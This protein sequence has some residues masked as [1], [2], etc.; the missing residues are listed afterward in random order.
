MTDRKT[1]TGETPEVVDAA[2][3]APVPPTAEGMAA[4]D[5]P[6]EHETLEAAVAGAAAAVQDAV[7][8][9]AERKL[10]IGAKLPQGIVL[11]SR[12]L[13]AGGKKGGGGRTAMQQR[14]PDGALLPHV[15]EAT[16]LS[17]ANKKYLV[18]GDGIMAPFMALSLRSHGI[19][20][21]LAHHQSASDLD[22]GTI[23]LT[24]SVT[25]LLGDVLNVSVPSGSVVGR[26]LIFDHVGNDM[27]DMD[28]NEFREKGESPT[29]F[30]C[31]RPKI[32][33]ALLSLC[34][35]GAQSCTVMPKATVEKGGVQ[36]CGTGVR[37]TFTTGVSHDY[38]GIICTAR[39]Q[40][41]VPELTLTNEELQRREENNQRYKAALPTANRWLEVCVPPLPELKKF[42]KRFTPGSQEIVEILT[43]REAKMT[44][45][46]TMMATKLFYNVSLVIPESAS[47]PL[48]RS[49]SMKQFWDEVVEH[50]TSGIPGYISHTLFKP[51]FTHVQ[52][53]FKKTHACCFRAPSFVLPY[54][55]E[56]DGRVMKIAHS[57][58]ACNHDAIDI[59]DAQ[60]FS[61]C[62]LL[63]RA[64]SE[65]K[66][67]PAFL[68]TR[69]LQVLEE[70][71][72]HE[73]ITNFS[74]RE[75]GQFAYMF[76][77]FQMKILRRYTRAWKQILKNHVSVLPKLK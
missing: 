50:W 26:I 13:A 43:P 34:K 41:L 44:V 37:V 24:P 7:A 4:A 76:S 57:V 48:L 20:C 25:Q 42:E 5:A 60:G 8:P 14:G 27:A 70:T 30:A 6:T 46:P 23:V 53:H 28:L 15:D 54:W 65:G 59:T 38:A 11:G 39:N 75:R 62:F 12:A 36:A 32:E 72:N 73:I 9:V 49:T 55:S 40:A 68:E 1:A 69:R 67:I 52:Q 29:F 77:R 2:A 58:H 31:D 63:A 45:R 47:N 64:I 16:G 22:R 51:M 10:S 33:L 56:G 74:L 18:I 17:L 3:T 35:L 71:N 61:D 66:D 19:E 21:D